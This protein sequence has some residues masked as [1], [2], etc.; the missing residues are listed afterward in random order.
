MEVKGE[1][2]RV[3]QKIEEQM[4]ENTGLKGLVRDKDKMVAELE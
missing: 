4:V 1:N 3:M 2:R